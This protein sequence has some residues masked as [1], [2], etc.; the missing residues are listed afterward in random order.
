MG[1]WNEIEPSD[2]SDGQ[3]GGNGGH[4]EIIVQKDFDRDEALVDT[5][6]NHFRD[7]SLHEYYPACKHAFHSVGKA[8]IVS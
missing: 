1:V 5:A 2:Y 7:M 4:R 6:F 8:E 3:L